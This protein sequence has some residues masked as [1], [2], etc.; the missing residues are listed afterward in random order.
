[1][2]RIG[3]DNSYDSFAAGWVLELDI[4]E[5]GDSEG[6]FDV[7]D[8]DRGFGMALEIEIIE[9]LAYFGV[10][11]AEAASFLSH[12]KGKVLQLVVVGHV[13]FQLQS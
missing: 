5:G 12:L 2:F 3:V 1:M 13:G 11:E 4:D 6:G 10:D 7:V 9:N 8:D